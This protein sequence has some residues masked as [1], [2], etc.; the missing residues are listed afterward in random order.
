[1]ETIIGLLFILLPLIFK[2][3]GRKLEKA[4][5]AE[6]AGQLKELAEM[7]GG[8]DETP[9][10]QTWHTDP[11]FELEPELEPEPEPQP[12]PEQVAPVVVM[13]PVKHVPVKHVPVK[14]AAVK[15]SVKVKPKKVALE[16]KKE[17]KE[18][19]DPKKLIVYSEIMTPKYSEY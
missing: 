15:P 3:I 10:T 6:K 1:M 18:M 17:K 4:G 2:L 11:V 14:Q 19:I 7:I 16:E 9:A 5:Q 13:E 12:E 8:E